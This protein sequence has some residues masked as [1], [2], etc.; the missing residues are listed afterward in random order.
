MWHPISTAP[1]DRDLELGVADSDGVR[2]IPFPCRRV[3]GGWIKAETETRV[4]CVRRIGASGL[5]TG[6]R[7]ARRET[8]RATEEPKSWLTTHRSRPLTPTRSP[9][10]LG[11]TPKEV[12]AKQRQHGR[13]LT[14]TE[15]SGG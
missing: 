14:V 1:F 11:V 4:D 10:M 9:S 5:P 6:A 3:L 12:Y 2:A 8:L 15:Q 13:K 7:P